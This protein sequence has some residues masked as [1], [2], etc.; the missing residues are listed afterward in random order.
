MYKD[1][2]ARSI[3]KTISW[4]FWATLTTMALVFLFIGELEVAF[5]IGIMEV[6]LKM[7]IYF[8]HERTWD[9]IKFGKHEIKPVV[10][11][12]TGL[13]RSG[14]SEIAKN[15]C[16]KLKDHGY[17]TEHLD[18]TTIRKMFPETSFTRESVNEHIK[19]V[20]LLA[21]KLEEQ[22]VFVVASFLSPYKESREFVKNICNN[23][24]EVHISTP[25][26]ICEQRDTKGLYAQARN[27]QIQN[28]PG[29]NAPYESPDSNALNVDTS[30]I[31][32]TQASD[33]I[34]KKI[35]EYIEV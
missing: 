7:I 9:K 8:V 3:V 26:E 18:G 11:W 23:F 14:K 24:I 29:I 25:L 19:R 17:K 31:S 27:G 15:I 5:S 32:P 4:R 10:V 35:K 22:G 2:K 6:I 12:L 33:K 34:L 28:F 21:S 30:N 16:Q 1:T 20:G 13:T